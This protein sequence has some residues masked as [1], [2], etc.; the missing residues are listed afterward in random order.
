MW[1]KRK[2]IG[3]QDYKIFKVMTTQFSYNSNTAE[4]YQI[5]APH[6]INIIARCKDDIIMI[7]QYRI[8]TEDYSLELPGGII[9][10]QDIIAAGMREL[11][12]ETGY[13]GTPEIIG[14][15]HPNPALFTNQL[16]TL[17]VKDAYYIAA[18][19]LETFEDINVYH[20][21]LSEI[22]RKIAHGKITNALT[23]ASLMQLISR[24]PHL[25]DCSNE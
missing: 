14:T 11:E 13:T 24:Y 12:E 15:M 8:G 9:E 4:F 6:W 23:L 16:Y 17:Y 18:N 7:H 25:F 21:P 10:E 3:K 1:V 20:M 19:Q 5:E 22:Y 2:L